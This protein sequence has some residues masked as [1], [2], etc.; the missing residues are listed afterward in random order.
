MSK[1]FLLN[2][3]DGIVKTVSE[4]PEK[5]LSICRFKD[6]DCWFFLTTGEDSRIFTI[7]SGGD[8][9]EWL[10]TPELAN[11]YGLCC[12][13]DLIFSSTPEGDVFRY[14]AY[15]KKMTK[16]VG[17]KGKRTV[18]HQVRGFQPQEGNALS[19]DD[20]RDVLYMAFPKTK[21]VG[22]IDGGSSMIIE[23]GSQQD[24]FSYGSKSTSCSFG[25]PM[26]AVAT[27]S[28]KIIVSDKN[29]HVIWVFK[30]E[31]ISHSLIGIY[32]KPM[33]AGDRD[34]PLSKSMF[35]SPTSMVECSNKV[36]LI[37]GNNKKIKSIDTDL[38]TSVAIYESNNKVLGLTT[39]SYGTP[40]WIEGREDAN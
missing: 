26:S 36:L 10:E 17:S 25:C 14:D 6:L 23:L 35:S 20:A 7:D 21:S 16:V 31:D 3:S 13:S 12:S 1:L 11:G 38:M 27:K 39:D 29:Y 8:I 19:Y 37:D 15:S 32:G 5:T 9:E 40:Y 33:K 22:T 34:G 30:S 18:S 28:G 2:K 24:E 4:L